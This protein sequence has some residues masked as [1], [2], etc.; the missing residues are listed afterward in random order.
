METVQAAID[1]DENFGHPLL[2]RV[3][4]CSVNPTDSTRFFMDMFWPV[5]VDR[6]GSMARFDPYIDEVFE[7][8]EASAPNKGKPSPRAWRQPGK[9]GA[10]THHPVPCRIP[11]VY[12]RNHVHALV[13][14][15]CSI[16]F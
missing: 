7:K 10:S 14:V 4:E 12:V 3:A 9:T 13:H 1:A 16:L 5:S 8:L 2:D 6:L 11:C 15:W